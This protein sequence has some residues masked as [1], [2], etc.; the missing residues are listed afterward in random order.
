MLEDVGQ[1]AQLEDV[2]HNV[3]EDVGQEAQLEVAVHDGGRGAGGSSL[4]R[5]TRR[6]GWREGKQRMKP[7]RRASD[8][9]SQ[10]ATRGIAC[11]R[12]NC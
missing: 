8:D 3:L 9:R 2:A 12:Q 6:S 11:M 1:E 7:W 10:G 5:S 4:G